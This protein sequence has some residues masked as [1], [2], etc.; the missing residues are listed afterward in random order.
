MNIL[1]KPTLITALGVLM[2]AFTAKI[3]AQKKENNL[4]I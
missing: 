4:K 2:F 1:Q 3:N